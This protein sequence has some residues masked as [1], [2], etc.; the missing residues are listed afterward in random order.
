MDSKSVTLSRSSTGWFDRESRAE[1][2]PGNG[3]E[4]LHHGT[5]GWQRHGP[6][7]PHEH[8]GRDHR[9]VPE[10]SFHREPGLYRPLPSAHLLGKGLGGIR[11]QQVQPNVSVLLG[12]DWVSEGVGGG[13]LGVSWWEGRGGGRAGVTYLIQV[14]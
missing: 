13:W 14:V 9:H 4:P 3:H 12:E 11:V 2:S 5:L 1:V 8:R 6:A 7:V 10:P